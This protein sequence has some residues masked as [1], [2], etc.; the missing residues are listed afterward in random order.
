MVSEK[1]SWPPI[2][3]ELLWL[4]P[5]KSKARLQGQKKIHDVLEVHFDQ[6]A[7]SKQEKQL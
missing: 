5:T 3:L 6:L 2:Q 1:A 4:L 7:C